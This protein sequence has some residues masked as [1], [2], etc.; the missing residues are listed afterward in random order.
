MNAGDSSFAARDEDIVRVRV[1]YEREFAMDARKVL[2]DRSF[3]PPPEDAPAE[4]KRRW[5]IESF[6]EL[7]GSDRE[8]DHLDGSYVVLRD[9]HDEADYEWPEW[10]QSRSRRPR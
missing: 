1:T 9:E 8:Q 6:W 10:L 2:G 3:D 4:D 5:L 7:C